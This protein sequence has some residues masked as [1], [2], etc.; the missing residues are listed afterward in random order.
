M[1]LPT[2]DPPFF[3]VPVR[4]A[5]WSDSSE[6]LPP[7]PGAGLW[8]YPPGR[9]IPGDGLVLWNCSKTLIVQVCLISQDEHS[10][11]TPLLPLSTLATFF[12]CPTSLGP[13]AYCPSPLKPAQD[14]SSE[15]PAFFHH[16]DNFFFFEKNVFFAIS[17]ST[18]LALS[19]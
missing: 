18:R 6:P 7:Q 17:C 1:V 13:I 3:L 11:K 2:T 9:D 10:S 12:L 15:R 8:L 14:P 16:F 5:K 19:Y 4:A